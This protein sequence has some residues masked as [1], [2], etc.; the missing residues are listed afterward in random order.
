MNL[1]QIF[2]VQKKTLDFSFPLASEIRPKKL[3]A[4]LQDLGLNPQIHENMRQ[5]QNL[6]KKCTHFCINSV[7][8]A[9]FHE[10]FEVYS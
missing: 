8:E 4:I 5:R 1:T 7:L 6:K 10:Y 9:K 2:C 3:L